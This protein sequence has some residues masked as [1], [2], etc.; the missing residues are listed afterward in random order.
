MTVNL[1]ILGMYFPS[2]DHND[3][4]L[5]KLA[6]SCARLDGMAGQVGGK[7][8]A[9]SRP[10]GHINIFTFLVFLCFDLSYGYV[11]PVADVHKQTFS[12]PYRQ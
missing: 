5:A 11:E 3:P 6:V 9:K 10:Q 12:I 8:R 4:K 2:K 1:G 7:L